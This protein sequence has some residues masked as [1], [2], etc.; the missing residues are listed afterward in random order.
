MLA[1]LLVEKRDPNLP[2]KYCKTRA[3]KPCG[4][5]RSGSTETGRGGR[6][7][8]RG[9]ERSLLQGLSQ[10][11]PAGLRAAATMRVAQCPVGAGVPER[12]LP[13][14]RPLQTTGLSEW[15]Q[16][17]DPNI[18]SAEAC[19]AQNEL[20]GQGHGCQASPH[21]GPDLQKHR[22]R[23][24]PMGLGPG[25]GRPLRWALLDEYATSAEDDTKSLPGVRGQ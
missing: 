19:L 21:F 14:G 24:L 15:G 13:K 1:F 25:W 11:L 5:W 22:H 9:S 18:A 12:Y 2:Y 3:E 23:P 16:C 8:E 4:V 20:R 7:A 17:N 6:A 10:G